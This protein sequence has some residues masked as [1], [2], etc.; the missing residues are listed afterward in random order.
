MTLLLSSPAECL[1]QLDH[2][3]VDLPDVIFD[4]APG[5]YED[6][7]VVELGIQA[8]PDTQLYP[9]D[10]RCCIR[11]T[12]D[13][14]EPT[15]SS[16]KYRGP[17]V[18]EENT[19]VR[20]AAF[21]YSHRGLVQEA[22][23]T[24]FEAPTALGKLPQLLLSGCVKLSRSFAFGAKKCA[25]R[26][27]DKKAELQAALGKALRL[28]AKKIA[29]GDVKESEDGQEAE[30]EFGVPT[31]A[32]ELCARLKQQTFAGVLTDALKLEGVQIDAVAV[33]RASCQ[34]LQRV[35]LHLAWDFPGAERELLDGLCVC[36]NGTEYLD[37]VDYRGPFSRCHTLKAGE[38]VSMKPTTPGGIA[39]K[40][41]EAKGYNAA[42]KKWRI[43]LDGRTDEV[44]VDC[45][46]LALAG[47]SGEKK[48]S[49]GFLA[50]GPICHS[51]DMLTQTGGKHV[52]TVDLAHVPKDCTD[53]VLALSS[54]DKKPLNAFPK[55]AVSL[56]DGGRWELKALDCPTDGGLRDR[57]PLLKTCE[58]LLWRRHKTPLIAWP[59]IRL[60]ALVDEQRA[61]L[62][63]SAAHEAEQTL[64]LFDLP[65]PL[66]LKCLAF[67]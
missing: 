60:G 8:R 16:P 44:L 14:S 42:E 35:A 32:Y 26:L 15:R 11:F 43:Q 22:L 53:V 19:M 39:G 58:R 61:V 52:L 21:S 65:Q 36:Y 57:P 29:I 18:V 31:D 62:K 12:T 9:Y 24:V 67:L 5:T 63:A 45:R 28:P 33:L 46:Y 3:V 64:L 59:L 2:S 49:T 13:G 25:E 10:C 30:F 56:F 4:P 48:K 54:Y 66:R 6:M 34:A 51:G 55:V 23:Y 40:R 7:V 50:R 38:F 1:A 47:P 20:A 37:Q 41:G 27:S 17:I